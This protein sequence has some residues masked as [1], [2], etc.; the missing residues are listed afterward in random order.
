LLTPIS[1][2][3]NTKQDGRVA[4][5]ENACLANMK[6]CVQTPVPSKIEKL[7]RCFRQRRVYRL[8]RADVN[9]YS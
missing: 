4:E 9:A 8:G 5:V 6:P 1:K 3:P 2:I 7:K